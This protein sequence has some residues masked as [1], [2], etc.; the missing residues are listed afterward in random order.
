MKFLQ[1]C[2][3]YLILWTA[4]L[5]YS[6]NVDLDTQQYYGVYLLPRKVKLTMC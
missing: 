4:S 3:K 5:L 1:A 2:G 6:E